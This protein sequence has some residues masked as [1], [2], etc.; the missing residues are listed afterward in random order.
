MPETWLREDTMFWNNSI[1]KSGYKHMHS[2]STFI[3]HLQ[4]CPKKL[5]IGSTCTPMCT[6]IHMHINFY[7]HLL[8]FFQISLWYIFVKFSLTTL[9]WASQQ[10]QES[11]LL[12]SFL[13][14]SSSVKHQLGM[15]HYRV[16]IFK[17]FHSDMHTNENMH[18]KCWAQGLTHNFL[19]WRWFSHPFSLP[20]LFGG[21]IDF[22][23]IPLLTKFFLKNSCFVIS[24]W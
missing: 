11:H 15:W 1:S 6:E 21:M 12:I 19:E 5:W 2:I 14:Y 23:T 3:Y 13:L 9:I 8:W 10:C 24:L 16:T 17:S 22:R 18:L 20:F 4:M 7:M